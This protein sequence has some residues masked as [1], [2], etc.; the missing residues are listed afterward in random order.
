MR[1]FSVGSFKVWFNGLSLKDKKSVFGFIE[2]FSFKSG[3][4]KK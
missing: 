2:R 1:K 4:L 3:G